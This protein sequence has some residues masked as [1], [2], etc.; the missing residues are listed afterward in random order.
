[1]TTGTHI[2]DATIRR[3]LAGDLRGEDALRVAG[4][5]AGECDVCE[6]HIAASAS[7]ASLDGALDEALLSLATQTGSVEQGNDIEWAR[8]QRQ[9]KPRPVRRLL[10]IGIAAAAVAVLAVGVTLQRGRPGGPDE[11]TGLKGIQPDRVS[12]RLR[13]SVS[14]PGPDAPALERGASGAV[15]P[16]EASLFFRIEASG[17]AQLVLLRLGPDGEVV[18]EGR[19]ERAGILDVEIGG[20]PAAY[21]LRGLSGRQR[22][23]LLAAPSVDR[24]ALDAARRM[25]IGSGAAGSP[26]PAVSLDLVEV[27]VR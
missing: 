6:A 15:V 13:F 22:F 14:L 11:W 3:L 24:E 12:A 2:D 18:W 10:A 23:A 4:H 19:A 21:P 9:L 5:L 27:T 17:P 20:R 25:L 16:P 1:M 8:I 26:G 7:A